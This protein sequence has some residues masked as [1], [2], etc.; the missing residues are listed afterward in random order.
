M[1]KGMVEQA[2]TQ[3]INNCDCC[4]E[5]IQTN[6]MA[7]INQMMVI[8]NFKC[9]CGDSNLSNVQLHLTEQQQELLQNYRLSR[10][11]DQSQNMMWCPNP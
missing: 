3:C 6:I 5:C 4:K 7:Q 1:R 8:D 9:I 2:K 11:I 10:E